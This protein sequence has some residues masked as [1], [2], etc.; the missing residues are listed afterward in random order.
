MKH[1]AMSYE[2]LIEETANNGEELLI[3]RPEAT[4]RTL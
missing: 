1:L 3:K 2:G 4:E